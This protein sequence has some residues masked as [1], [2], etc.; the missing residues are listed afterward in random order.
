[1]NKIKQ[2]L[3]EMDQVDLELL[4]KDLK[5]GHIQKYIDQKKDYFKLKDKV[6]PVCGSIV[7][8]ECFVLT[9]GEPT[10]RKKAHFC[11]SDCLGYYISNFI[12]KSRKKNPA[13]QL[14]K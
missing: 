2:F 8:E 6:C 9:W 1:M 14:K 4:E 5:E 10:L 3:D 11:G 7:G 12:K 13:R